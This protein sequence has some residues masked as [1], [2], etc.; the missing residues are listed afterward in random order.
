MVDSEKLK[1]EEFLNIFVVRDF[2][3]KMDEFKE[4]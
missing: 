3:D 1:Y 2:T 4:K